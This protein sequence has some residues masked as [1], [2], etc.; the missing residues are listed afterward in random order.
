[1][2]YISGIYFKA[3]LSIE[4]NLQAIYGIGKHRAKFLCRYLGFSPNL[5]IAYI[6]EQQELKLKTAI[7]VW[8][9]EDELRQ[10][11]LESIQRLKTIGSYRGLRHRQ[12]LPCRGQNTYSNARTRKN[13]RKNI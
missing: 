8:L 3:Q 1:M 11:N 10:Y 12:S 4:K 9:H 5:K 2:F 7:Q 6:T 13:F